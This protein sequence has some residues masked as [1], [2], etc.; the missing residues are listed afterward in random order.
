MKY[1][2]VDVETFGPYPGKYPLV[3]IGAIN[4]NT[5]EEFY[6]ELKVPID[7]YVDEAAMDIAVLGL[8]DE[9]VNVEQGIRRF[10]NWLMH[11]QDEI[12]EQLV[13]VSDTTSFDHAFINYYLNEYIGD[14]PFGHSSISLQQLYKGMKKDLRVTIH[15]LRK[16]EHSHNALEDCRGNVNVFE[17]LLTKGLKGVILDSKE[18]K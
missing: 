11:Q 13:F 4:Y 9:A 14:N 3:S 10:Y 1:I 12:D 2:I 7:A 16:V 5:R 8:K 18:E 15:N 6:V 17:H